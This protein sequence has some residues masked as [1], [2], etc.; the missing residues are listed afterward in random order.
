L[1]GP[2]I[3]SCKTAVTQDKDGVRNRRKNHN[4]PKEDKA[5][6]EAQGKV[7]ATRANHEYCHQYHGNKKKEGAVRDRTCEREKCQEIS[8]YEPDGETK[9]SL[10]NGGK[11]G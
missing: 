1:D 2:K 11:E 10:Q 8:R 3:K 4:L 9:K 5:T 7:A 6:D